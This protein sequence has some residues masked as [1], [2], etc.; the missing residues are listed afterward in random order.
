MYFLFFSP[1]FL[2][3]FLGKVLAENIWNEREINGIKIQSQFVTAESDDECKL[4]A[5]LS[6]EDWE[7]LGDHAKF[8]RHSLQISKCLDSSCCEPARSPVFRL[9]KARFVPP[10]YA[11]VRDQEGDIKLAN[12][13]KPESNCFY[14]DLSFRLGFRCGVEE[15]HY[16]TYNGELTQ[17][18]L[19]SLLCSVCGQ[20]F[21]NKKQVKL[22][23]KYTHQNTK[24]QGREEMVFDDDDEKALDLGRDIDTRGLVE[25]VAK[26]DDEY[27]CVFEDGH[28]EWMYLPSNYEEV[29]R[30]DNYIKSI[31]HEDNPPDIE[32]VI[33][34][35][36]WIKSPYIMD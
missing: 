19:K 25:V 26:R 6:K 8:S 32:E 22:H 23:R 14:P 24:S 9:L 3:L 2:C 17:S 28:C 31:E 30:Y 21:G 10:P 36:E 20:Q 1:S 29:V 11:L 16:D 15:L 27:F 4:N 12:P 7:Y 13:D 18:D 33:N 34:Y 35:G 5:D